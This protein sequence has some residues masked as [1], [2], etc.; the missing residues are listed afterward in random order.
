MKNI[1]N[2]LNKYFESARNFKSPISLEKARI[3]IENV[4]W[5]VNIQIYLSNRLPYK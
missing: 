4:G 1:D 5:V 3:L 2:N